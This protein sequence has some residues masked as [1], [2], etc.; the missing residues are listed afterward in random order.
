MFILRSRIKKKSLDGPLTTKE[1]QKIYEK[2][3]GICEMCQCNC[4]RDKKHMEQYLHT[5]AAEDAQGNKVELTEEEKLQYAKGLIANVDHIIPRSKGGDNSPDNLRLL[6]SRCNKA[7]N[8]GT[9][10]EAMEKMC[11]EEIFQYVLQKISEISKKQ[12]GIWANWSYKC[13]LVEINDKYFPPPLSVR[14]KWIVDMLELI[15]KERVDIFKLRDEVYED[16]KMNHP[17]RIRTYFYS[18]GEKVDG[19]LA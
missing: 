2:F 19:E 13:T 12:V 4:Y 6:C 10:A 5:I 1:R 16:Y 8:K 17:E 18:L 11:Y 3:N 15:T 9:D 14:S 7:K